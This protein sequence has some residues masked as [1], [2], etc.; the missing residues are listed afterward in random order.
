MSDYIKLNFTML[1]SVP[2]AQVPAMDRV[3]APD[4]LPLYTSQKDLDIVDCFSFCISRLRSQFPVFKIP[5]KY[6]LDMCG[7]CTFCEPAL[8]PFSW[9]GLLVTCGAYLGLVP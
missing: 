5:T 8:T 6:K 1:K 2:S 9:F 3:L 4:S 7:Y